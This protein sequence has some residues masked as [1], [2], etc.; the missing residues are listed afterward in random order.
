MFSANARASPGRHGGRLCGL[1]TQVH[2]QPKYW[3]VRED[4]LGTVQEGCVDIWTFGQ[5]FDQRGA[6][7]FIIDPT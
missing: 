4:I 5:D 3:W 7:I 2:P 1:G 6:V